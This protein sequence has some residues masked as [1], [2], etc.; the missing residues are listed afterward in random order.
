MTNYTFNYEHGYWTTEDGS[1]ALAGGHTDML[2]K[3]LTKR[4]LIDLLLS[5]VELS[6]KAI[7]A[8]KD[9]S[10]FWR[11]ETV[12]AERKYEAL[13]DSV[14]TLRQNIHPYSMAL[15]SE[16]AKQNGVV[17]VGL[18]TIAREWADIEDKL[19][20]LCRWSEVLEDDDDEDR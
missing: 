17:A 8:A 19:D 6:L 20:E 7:E 5:Q 15:S 1:A 11:K 10:S 4:Q 9:R 3:R 2:M 14:R 12:A 18:D 16:A 13:L